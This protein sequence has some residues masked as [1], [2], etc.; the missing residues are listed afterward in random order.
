MIRR[1]NTLRRCV[2]KNPAAG[3]GRWVEVAP[4]RFPTWIDEFARRHG[5]A[6]AV[7]AGEAGNVV[8]FTAADGAMAE[9]HVPFPPLRALAAEAP[10]VA[11]AIAA[12]AT[13]DRTVGVLLVRLG[14]YAV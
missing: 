8:S 4:G 9:C 12:H 10:A 3:G 14:G 6:A 7:T 11:R 2:V 13:A 5:A 1:V